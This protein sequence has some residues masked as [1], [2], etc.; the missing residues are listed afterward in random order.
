[1]EGKGEG[2]SNEKLMNR[3]ERKRKETNIPEVGRRRCWSHRITADT[4]TAL[5]PSHNTAVGTAHVFYQHT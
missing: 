1:M 3:N 2:K 4:I 5:T